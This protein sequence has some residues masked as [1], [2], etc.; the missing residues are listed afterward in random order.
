MPNYRRLL[1]P[2]GTYFFTVNLADRRSDL[3][4]KHI[5]HLRQAWRYTVE[6]HTFETVAVVILPDHLHTIWT[7]PEGDQDFQKRW[8]LIKTEFTRA[9]PAADKGEGRRTGER[10]VWQR[11]YWEHAIRDE[12]D[13]EAHIGYIHWNPVKHGYV[14]D[15]DDWPH[16][17]WHRFKTESGLTYDAEAW[18]AQEFGERM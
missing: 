14:T 4:V 12:A 6:R 1:V 15:I 17:S 11:R 8:R 7:L 2:G 16:S 10:G 3:L 9:L 13:L 5:D 18:K